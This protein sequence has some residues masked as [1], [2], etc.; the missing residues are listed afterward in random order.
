[1]QQMENRAHFTT[2]QG[3][4]G[5]KVVFIDM[6]DLCVCQSLYIYVYICIQVYA[7]IYDR[8]LPF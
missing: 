6:N 7:L 3:L 4:G 2:Q 1:M 5:L 8:F